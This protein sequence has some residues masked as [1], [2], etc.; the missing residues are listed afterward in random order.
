MH[1]VKT[2]IE[3]CDRYATIAKK[4]KGT[5]EIWQKLRV[6]IPD[7]PHEKKFQQNELYTEKKF[8]SIGTGIE[9]S[10]NAL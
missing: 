8:Q 10:K 1:L 4:P 6:V 3:K 7:A 5:F 9:A 2:C